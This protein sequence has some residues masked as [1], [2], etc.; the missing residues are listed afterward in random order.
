MANHFTKI[1]INEL[2]KFPENIALPKW[3]ES[4]KEE[5]FEKVKVNLNNFAQRLYRS[6]IT[7]NFLSD[8]KK[9]VKKIHLLI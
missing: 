6:K 8:R 3:F 7:E 5:E 4:F 2:Y 9:L 1:K